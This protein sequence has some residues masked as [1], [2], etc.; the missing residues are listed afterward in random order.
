MSEIIEYLREFNFVS[1]TVRLLLAMLA[2]AAVGYGRTLNKANA[3]LRTYMITSIGAALTVLISMYEYSMLMGE[4]KFAWE[5]GDLKFDG[6]RFS[7]Q[8]VAGIGFIAAGAVIAISHRQVSGLTSAIGLFASACM[9]I[10]AGAGF[11]E[12]VLLSVLIIIVTME[13]MLPMEVA[14]KRRLRNMTV[15]VE[16]EKTEDIS[17]VTQAITEQNAVIFDLDMEYSE[18]TEDHYPTAIMVIKLS[19]QNASHSGLLSS[20]AE[21]PCVH[22]IQELIS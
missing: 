18:R 2:G 6:T 10:A 20:V 9:G 21:L 16:F 1:M 14:F 8:V 12:C 17:I 5:G 3:G 11:Y 4:W 19:K 22:S 15:S 13:F 7:A